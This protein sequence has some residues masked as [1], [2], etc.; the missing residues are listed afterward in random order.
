[1][2]VLPKLEKGVNILLT[3]IGK[4]LPISEKEISWLT[5]TGKGTKYLPYLTGH[6]KYLYR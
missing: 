4:G 6:W 1:M 3:Y 2:Y 5:Y